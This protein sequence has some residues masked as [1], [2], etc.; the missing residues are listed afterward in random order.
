MSKP[1]FALIYDFDKTLA[2]FDM[3]NYTFIPALGLTPAEFW[4]KTSEV[5][6][7]NKMESIL[8]YMYMMM[9]CCK[10]KNIPLTR[11]F[12]NDC[13]KNIEFFPGVLTWFKRIN[14]YGA[15][16]GVKIEHYLVSSGNLEIIQGT[17]IY[18]EFKKCFGC[19]F[20]FDEKT[21]EA[22]WPKVAINYT[23]KTQYI[24]RISKG[25]FDQTDDDN[26]N[27]K[28]KNRRI[29]YENMVYI[30]DGMTDIPSM[31]LINQQGG[32]TIAI[33]KGGAAN[34]KV[35]N[36]LIRDKRCNYICKAKYDEGSPIENIVKKLIDKTVLDSEL[37]KIDKKYFDK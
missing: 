6:N 13:G 5:G 19:E 8:S 12:L 11:K 3:Q 1:I 28:T 23:Q 25:V 36:T 22:I 33:Y 20:L 30:G 37:H 18:K 27:K 2:T 14:K 4:G 16:K 21:K 9:Y 26:V 17:E 15:K 35:L 32:S 7:K 10:E 34:N 31:V 29:K 24:F